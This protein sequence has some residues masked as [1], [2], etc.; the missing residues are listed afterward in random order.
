MKKLKDIKKQVIDTLVKPASYVSILHE[1]YSIIGMETYVLFNDKS[2]RMLDLSVTDNEKYVMYEMVLPV[3]QRISRV[4][5][6]GVKSHS[7]DIEDMMEIHN[8]LLKKGKSNTK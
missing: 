4:A 8:M 2:G 6:K 1:P 7:Q 3:D 5:L